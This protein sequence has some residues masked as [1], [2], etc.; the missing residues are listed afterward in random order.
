LTNPFPQGQ[1]LASASNTGNMKEGNQNAPAT[2]QLYINMANLDAF[3][4]TQTK[5]NNILESSLKNQEGV[6]P[7]VIEKPVV[8]TIPRMLKGTYKRALH[9]FLLFSLLG[10]SLLDLGWFL[11]P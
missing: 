1:N 2:D 4:S 3:V 7:L 6:D 11:A 8:E 5:Y 10:F 9:T